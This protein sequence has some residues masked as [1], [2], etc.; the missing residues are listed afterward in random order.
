MSFR[1]Q[2]CIANGFSQNVVDPTPEK[3]YEARKRKRNHPVD[4]AD[5][6]DTDDKRQCLDD[7]P[8][9]TPSPSNVPLNKLPVV[10]DIPTSTPSSSNVPLNK[11]PVVGD[12]PTSTPSPSNVPLNKLPVVGD[13]PT[14]TPSSSNVPLNKLPV[15]GDIP[16]STPSSSNVP[17]NKLPVVGDI[18]TS[19]PSSSNVPLNKLP[20]VGDIPTS[21]PSSS[22]VPL[23]KLPVV[24]DIPTSTP[25]SSNVPL[26]KL[27]VVGDIPTSIPSSSNVPLNKLPVVGDIPTSTPSSSNVPLN[28][29]PVVGDIPTSTPSSSNVP[30]NKLPVVGDI[31]TSTPSSSNV[32]LNKLPVVGWTK[33]LSMLPEFN[34]INIRSY[35]TKSGKTAKAVSSSHM[36]SKQTS[37]KYESRGHHFHSEQYLHDIWVKSVDETLLIKAKCFRSLS[38]KKDPHSLHVRIDLNE[39]H[40]VIYAKCSCVAGL[41]GYCNHVIGLLYRIREYYQDGKSSIPDDRSKASEPMMWN[42]PRI[43]GIAPEAVTDCVVRKV[44]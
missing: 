21:I 27:P 31:P 1:V 17:L 29:L 8:T 43:E 7:I 22:N 36:S 5:P 32:P 35:T 33:S 6:D 15:V 24:G 28:K 10:G 42:R 38:K 16:T 23:N 26:N 44:K 41:S 14:S 19:T 12:I 40:D 13:I 18:P 39:P 34:D 37:L 9:S 2:Q 11:L 30:L 25:S 3:L 20:V 4:S